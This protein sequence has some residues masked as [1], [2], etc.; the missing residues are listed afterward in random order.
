MMKE[1]WELWGEGCNDRL[2][3][4]G[5]SEFSGF[6]YPV[7]LKVDECELGGVKV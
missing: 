4:D 3:C 1:Y 2:V 6:E 5:E 7:V